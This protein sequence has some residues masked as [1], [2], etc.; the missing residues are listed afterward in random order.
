MQPETSFF[1]W[2][3]FFLM[4]MVETVEMHLLRNVTDIE[5][6]NIGLEL[7]WNTN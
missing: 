4:T 3:N 2:K 1:F 6:Q 5:K 7:E